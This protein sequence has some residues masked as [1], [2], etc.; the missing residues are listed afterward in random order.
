MKNSK[1]FIWDHDG[2]LLDSY[3]MIVSSL[4]ETYKEY[5]IELNKEDIHKHVIRYSVSSFI[6]K[7]EERTGIKFESMKKRYSEISDVKKLNIQAIPNDKDNF[8]KMAEQGAE[9][10]VFTHRGKSTE[11]VLKNLE[12]YHYFKEIISSQSGFPRKPEP[13]AINYLIKKYDLDRMNTYYVGDRTVD[14]D[15]AKNA[16]VNGILFLPTNSFC[17]ANGSEN[18]IVHN[19]LEIADL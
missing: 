2:T 7:M 18:Y 19:L 13:D 3:E 8:G 12:L 9:N 17:E 15:C 1:A 10:F 16:K 4:Y 14:M 11:T 6:Q 5:G